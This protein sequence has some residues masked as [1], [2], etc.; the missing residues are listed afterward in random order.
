MSI[1]TAPLL[2]GQ[3]TQSIAADNA[4]ATA[5]VSAIAQQKHIVLGCE[6]HYSAAVSLI[7]TVTLK[8]GSTTWQTFRWDFTNGPFFF[9]LPV[10]LRGALN[11]AVS[12][13]LEASGTGGTSGYASIYTAT[14]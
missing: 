2:R 9:A 3:V 13:E 8:H 14:D 7:K 4:T 11:E 6:A 1:S 12:V 10:A 5:S